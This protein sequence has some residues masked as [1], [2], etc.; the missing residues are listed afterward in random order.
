MLY[1]QCAGGTCPPEA[2]IAPREHSARR[3]RG[4]SGWEGGLLRGVLRSRRRVDKRMP[5]RPACAGI[6]LLLA[7]WGVVTLRESD[8]RDV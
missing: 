1:T 3:G 5:L 7:A 4:H 8:R 6:F 2:A